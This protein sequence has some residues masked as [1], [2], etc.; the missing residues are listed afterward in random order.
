MIPYNNKMIKP[1]LQDKDRITILPQK[2]KEE[3]QKHLIQVQRLHQKD[4][5][6]G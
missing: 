1:N 6:E 3:M 2:I 5:R 4:L